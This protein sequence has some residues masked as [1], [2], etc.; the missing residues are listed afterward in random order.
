MANFLWHLAR[1]VDILHLPVVLTLICWAATGK[2]FGKAYGSAFTSA[3][4]ASQ[5]ACLGCP[6]TMLSQW[7]RSFK[8]P[9]VRPSPSLTHWLYS[10]LDGLGNLHWILS[11][12]F[13]VAT[14]L[15]VIKGWREHARRKA[16]SAQQIFCAN[17]DKSI[18]S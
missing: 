13:L 10:H 9:E 8:N 17:R 12:V 18:H 11:G 15:Y 5:L 7:L 16:E 14:I 1:V 2:Y 6:V 4:L 3:I